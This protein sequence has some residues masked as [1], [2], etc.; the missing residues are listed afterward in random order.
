M[1]KNSPISM[2]DPAQ[3]LKRIYVEADDAFRVKSIAGGGLITEVWDYLVVTYPTATTELYTFKT[4]G[5]GGTTVNA[6]TI[7]YTD[8]TKASISTVVKT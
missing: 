4:G 2:L 7:T 1:S 3:T 8:S 5:S 6:V